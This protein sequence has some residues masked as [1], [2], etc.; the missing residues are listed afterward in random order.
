MV[1]VKVLKPFRD[2]QEDTDREPGDVF[3]AT[4]A[5]ASH[6]AHV[7]PGYVEFVADDAT[8]DEPDLVSLKVAELRA[9]AEERGVDVPRNAKRADLVRALRG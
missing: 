7:L 8:V 2:L 9:L 3:D 6:I 1:K 4:E 5:R